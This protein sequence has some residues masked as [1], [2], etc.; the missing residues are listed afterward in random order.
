MNFYDITSIIAGVTIFGL[1]IVA[2]Y[3]IGQHSRKYS[4]K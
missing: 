1:V 2:A 3:R 4:H